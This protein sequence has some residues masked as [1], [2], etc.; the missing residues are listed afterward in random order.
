MDK[1]NKNKITEIDPLH[2]KSM[3][4]VFEL[5][6]KKPAMYLGRKSLHDFNSWLDGFSYALKIID[7]NEF[8]IDVDLVSFDKFVQEKYDWHDVGGWLY[9]IKYR[10]RDEADAFDEFFRLYDEFQL[11]NNKE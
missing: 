2:P 9:K 6:R 7:D 8:K 5:I 10:Y 4:E 1:S 11:M 3:T